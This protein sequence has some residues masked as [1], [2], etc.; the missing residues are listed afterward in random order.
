MYIKANVSK[1]RQ[2]WSWQ[3]KQVIM[4]TNKKN[5]AGFPDYTYT[6]VLRTY[7]EF[8]PEQRCKFLHVT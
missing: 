4:S 1:I 3:L 6:K 7:R 5:K 2:L 8:K